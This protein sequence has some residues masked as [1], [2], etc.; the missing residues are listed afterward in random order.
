[1]FILFLRFIAKDTVLWVIW[2]LSKELLEHLSCPIVVL[3]YQEIRQDL[4]KNFFPK[5][6]IGENILGKI[7]WNHHTQNN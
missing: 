7:D 5:C 4:F 3:I 1:M 6:L 2:E